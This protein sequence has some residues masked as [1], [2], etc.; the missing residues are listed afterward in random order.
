VLVKEPEGKV[1]E[2]GDVFTFNDGFRS[3]AFRVKFGSGMSLKDQGPERQEARRRIEE[4]RKPQ[5]EAALVRLMKAR[6]TLPYNNIVAEITQQ[7]SPRFLPTTALIK[8]R[9]E[10]L[11]E[12]MFLERDPQDHRIYHYVA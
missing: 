12:R 3:K 1:V 4:D 6:R 9:V 5:V 2:K 10:S 8:G 11:V 7:L